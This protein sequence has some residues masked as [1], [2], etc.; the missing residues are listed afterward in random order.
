MTTKLKILAAVGLVIALIIIATVFLNRLQQD[1]IPPENLPLPATNYTAP[2]INLK[3]IASGDYKSIQKLRTW[4]QNAP[5]DALKWTEQMSDAPQATA[6]IIISSAWAKEQPQQAA[7]WVLSNSTL[8]Q[9]HTHLHNVFRS[10]TDQNIKQA[11]LAAE[12]IPIK[13][14][15]RYWALRAVVEKWT[16]KQAH[17]AAVYA[18]KKN[19]TEPQLNLVPLVVSIWQKQDS[20]AARKWLRTVNSQ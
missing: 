15:G 20:H 2:E 4:A 14:P 18:E 17:T 19:K 12:K 16:E 11:L 1:N 6:Q 13:A 5:L 10:W 9:R 7:E 8:P 3:S